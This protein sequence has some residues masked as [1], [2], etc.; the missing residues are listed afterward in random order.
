[1]RVLLVERWVSGGT[2]K[3]AAE[4]AKSLA[5]GLSRAQQVHLLAAESFPYS[6]PN[7]HIHR[8]LSSL[9][10]GQGTLLRRALTLRAGREQQSNQ[11]RLLVQKLRPDI[12]HVLGTSALSSSLLKQ[13][14][15]YGG[16]VVLT[17]HDLPSSKRGLMQVL[18][19]YWSRKL[20]EADAIVAHGEWTRNQ[21]LRTSL[22]PSERI[23]VIPF[24]PLYFGEPT[25]TPSALRGVFGLN[26]ES[27][28]GL[29]FGSLRWEKGLD[30]LIQAVARSSNE[31]LQFL[32]A[33]NSPSRGE[34]P[35]E[36]YVHLAEE[37]KVASRFRWFEGYVPDRQVAN[38]MAS[39]NFCVC[40][41]R[42]T[43]S[44]QSAVL[45]TAAAYK[46]P[47]VVS[48]VG[49]IGATVRDWGIGWSV[50]PEDPSSLASALDYLDGSVL[51]NTSWEIPDWPT[52]AGKTWDLYEKVLST[53]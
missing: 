35:L 30:I 34:K 9:Y 45:M 29:F 23:R 7:V 22:F 32:V 2:A 4:L 18:F 1:M 28:T 31:S 16:S 14:K 52:A 43:F 40:P 20:F 15:S 5:E 17:V 33:V 24:G 11:I 13:V 6:P 47:M 37:M 46:V 42:R 48:D 21:I 25:E 50:E 51:K 49:E 3:Y 41:Y 39:A 53:Y 36:W 12:V 26:A 44:A 10:G 8:S 27:L 19:K 38:Y